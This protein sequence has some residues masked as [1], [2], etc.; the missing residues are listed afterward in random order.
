MLCY[1]NVMIRIFLQHFCTS[2]SEARS[3]RETSPHLRRD[4][5]TER[6]LKE[7]DA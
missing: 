3:H 1:E 2:Q 6:S 7:R 5:I 4:E